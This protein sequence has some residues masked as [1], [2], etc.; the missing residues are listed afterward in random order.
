MFKLDNKFWLSVQVAAVVCAYLILTIPVISAIN[1]RTFLPG[2]ET[3]GEF[4]FDPADKVERAFSVS[5]A[6]NRY[7]D[8]WVDVDVVGKDPAYMVKRI[9]LY[10]CRSAYPG[11]CSEEMPIETVNYLSGERKTFKWS[12]DLAV[13]KVANFMTL[14]QLEYEGRGIWIGFWD[15]VERKDVK[16]F[17]H[18]TYDI[19]TI[20]LHLK[21]NVDVTWVENYIRKNFMIP[22]DWMSHAII[23]T[24]DGE[25]VTKTDR[26]GS[27]RND[28]IFHRFVTKSSDAIVQP[29][30]YTYNFV[31]G[32]DVLSSPLTF[33]SEPA[34]SCG[35]AFCDADLGEDSSSCCID[36]GCTL[37]GESCDIGA[38]YPYGFCHVCGDKIWHPVENS[39]S[40]C[41]DAGCPD[42][43]SC[44]M[45][46]VQHGTCVPPD[47]GNGRCDAPPE[48]A[49]NCCTDCGGDSGCEIMFGSD[50][51]CNQN[52]FKCQE[53]SCGDGTCEP[54]EG[55]QTCCTD[56]DNCPAGEYCDTSVLDSGICMIPT[57]GNG[58]C[59]P[60][61]DYSN[62]CTD[63]NNCPN[64]PYTGLGQVCTNNVCHV[65]GNNNAESVETEADCCIDT[66]CSTGYCAHDYSCRD[67]DE[68]SLNVIV[69]PNEGINC[70][71]EGDVIEDMKVVMSI[72][73]KPEF[74]ERFESASYSFS[75]ISKS[76]KN[77]VENGGAYE[78]HI[79]L[80]GD[81][82]FQGC[83]EP[84]GMQEM[85]VSVDAIYYNDSSD[86]SSNAIVDI[87][88]ENAVNVTVDRNRDR[89][90]NMNDDKCDT[91][92]GE[93]FEM[94]CHDCGCPFGSVCL[95][96][97]CTSE[98]DLTIVVDESSIPASDQLVCNRE[99]A[100]LNKVTF[101][102]S[103]DNLPHTD[104][105]PFA[106]VNY[107]LE[108]DG[109][110]YTQYNLSRFI[111]TPETTT[112]NVLTGN[113][114][115]E[116]PISLFPAC[117]YTSPGDFKFI[118]WI[119]G[120]G[121]SAYHDE[122]TGKMIS[123][124][125][126]ISYTQGLP[127]CN[128]GHYTCDDGE[129]SENC[130]QDCGCADGSLCSVYSGCVS[131]SDIGLTVWASP[132][133]L[134]CSI[135]SG[136]VIR[137]FVE[138]DP[139][140]IGSVL[141][142]DTILDDKYIHYECTTGLGT[143]H[144]S[145][146]ILECERSF[147]EFEYCWGVYGQSP[148]FDYSLGFDTVFSYHNGSAYKDIQF[149]ESVD[150]TVTV[151][152]ERSCSND[153]IC[154]PEDGE[155]PE[156]CCIGC[157]CPDEQNVCTFENEC[158]PE[159]DVGLVVTNYPREV[160]CSKYDT[161][162]IEVNVT[163]QPAWSNNVEWNMSI[164][165]YDST[166]IT[167]HCDNAHVHTENDYLC[168]LSVRDLPIC[169]VAGETQHLYDTTLPDGCTQTGGL[170]EGLV[171]CTREVELKVDMEYTKPVTHEQKSLDVDP[172][173]MT[174]TGKDIFLSCGNDK[175]EEDLN[176]RPGT[177]CEDCACPDGKLCT[178]SDGCITADDI[179]LVL[180]DGEDLSETC[181]LLV[182]RNF[183]YDEFLPSWDDIEEVGYECAFT[184]PVEM[185][186]ALALGD[187]NIDLHGID[188]ES[189]SGIYKLL[190]YEDVVNSQSEIGS[191]KDWK[192]SFLMPV[193][194]EKSVNSFPE[195][196]NIDISIDATISTP[197]GD[198]ALNLNKTIK[199]E[200]E[201]TDSSDLVSLE[202]TIRHLRLILR[203]LQ[204]NLG[205][206]ALFMGTCK[207]CPGYAPGTGAVAKYVQNVDSMKN[208]FIASGV[209]MVASWGLTRLLK[210][211]G[212]DE[213]IF[214]SIILTTAGGYTAGLL[215]G[216]I[217]LAQP[218]GQAFCLT[219]SLRA[220]ACKAT[221]LTWVILMAAS[222][223]AI[224]GFLATLK[225]GYDRDEKLA[226]ADAGD[227]TS[228]RLLDPGSFKGG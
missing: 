108:Y 11:S 193:L 135:S 178:L 60:D 208:V 23:G 49:G 110:T 31:F 207:V 4:S 199:M 173:D 140:P 2:S 191:L 97:S 210:S 223:G 155:L 138:V 167:R 9:Y 118:A 54:G 58:N 95:E 147:S 192:V 93:N 187:S 124:E 81:D 47:C 157:G 137:F 14:V 16:F 122:Y 205:I 27:N 35:D 181:T 94:C 19:D 139:K 174:M 160:N 87:S 33:Y 39:A 149:N 220:L 213:S 83:F 55:S 127:K 152:R 190:E 96:N 226:G 3:P 183:N 12:G 186:Y 153:N 212:F 18:Y 161:I 217:I 45:T 5:P 218:T 37:E 57:C 85:T 144:A 44:D 145:D 38:D 117:P 36:C 166:D 99:D 25:T 113:V 221:N 154:N 26:I 224:L 41:V 6:E 177:C 65:C 204:F 71:Q 159:S 21:E 112:G 70:M 211:S 51:Y 105:D 189:L 20:D 194:A 17:E 102:A 185:D 222:G 104:G 128:D 206:L 125:F 168:E 114:F 80:S 68:M 188:T 88:L 115:C 162:K 46:N 61:E 209:L 216:G 13:G 50:S 98:D 30:D 175:C 72:V 198:K 67:R 180:N 43:F 133:D 75:G 116:I 1:V 158:K 90:C 111:C 63:C 92:I 64:D 100:V 132:E 142:G 228:D 126:S 197:N 7:D 42:G 143:V 79:P 196:L 214:N 109:K 78:C 170:E 103:V 172:Y 201:T 150:F 106:L 131:Q 74:F 165:G 48:N 123:D 176:E 120:G 203:V 156:Q 76:M 40:C 8:I 169:K 69:L 219:P 227:D 136:K 73:N 24:V 86:Y 52:T 10:T 184:E 34:T 179:E 101:T 62:C 215:V 141:F 121:L 56:C 77:C 146:Y 130:C 119:T 151:P 134:D 66:G 107:A 129:T 32:K 195:E 91:S 28:I 163:D 202:D 15:Q 53:P 22:S 164:P 29:S 171:S 182:S 84:V 59:E 225:W 89:V 148:P 82:I 200:I